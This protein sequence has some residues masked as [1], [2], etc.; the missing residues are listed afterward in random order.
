[1]LLIVIVATAAAVTPTEKGALDVDAPAGAA[2]TPIARASEAATAR[3]FCKRNS[4]L[5]PWS[6]PCRPLP[7]SRSK[8]LYAVSAHAKV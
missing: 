8:R 7:P 3:R 4:L 5:V 2:Q 6:H 1:L